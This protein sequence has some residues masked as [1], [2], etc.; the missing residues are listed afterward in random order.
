MKRQLRKTA[1]VTTV[2]NPCICIQTTLIHLI[3]TLQ[4]GAEKTKNETAVNSVVVV[5]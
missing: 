1:A 5:S 2:K 4:S 3:S